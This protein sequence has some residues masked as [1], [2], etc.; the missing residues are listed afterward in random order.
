MSG[1]GGSTVRSGLDGATYA[2]LTDLKLDLDLHCW[3]VDFS[4][5]CTVRC[6]VKRHRKHL[7]RA[8]RRGSEEVEGGGVRQNRKDD[9]DDERD[10]RSAALQASPVLQSMM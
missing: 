8:G 4:D 5:R 2:V 9:V 3:Y 10:D 6:A 1:V 7:A